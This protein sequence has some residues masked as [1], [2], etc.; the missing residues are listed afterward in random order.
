MSPWM[1]EKDK[2]QVALVLIDQGPKSTDKKRHLGHFPSKEVQQMFDQATVKG[3]ES[4]PWTKNKNAPPL[5]IQWAI[6]P[7]NPS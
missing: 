3:I 6:L 7:Y 4:I 2:R 1:T 5:Q